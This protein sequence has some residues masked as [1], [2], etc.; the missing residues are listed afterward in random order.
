METISAAIFRIVESHNVSRFLPQ[1]VFAIVQILLPITCGNSV[2]QANVP[3]G[4]VTPALVVTSW[5]KYT[6]GVAGYSKG[7]GYPR[8]GGM[9]SQRRGRVC[10]WSMRCTYSPANEVIFSK[11]S[12]CPRGGG[13]R[14]VGTSHVLWDG[15]HIR[16]PPPPTLDLG[17]SPSLQTSDLGT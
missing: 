16:Y 11:A 1:K 12:V 5:C 2:R 8:G 4:C 10:T 17:T 14:G 3:V 9:V 6:G 13:G 7:I 15:S